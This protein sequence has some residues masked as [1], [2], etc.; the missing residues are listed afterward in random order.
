MPDMTDAQIHDMLD[1]MQEYIRSEVERQI[2]ERLKD[3]EPTQNIK[4][5]I[6]AG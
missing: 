2:T 6:E 1:L 5:K 3:W 4:I